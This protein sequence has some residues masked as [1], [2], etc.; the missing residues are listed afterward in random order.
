MKL[1]KNIVHGGFMIRNVETYALVERK[2]VTAGK[3]TGNTAQKPAKI[4]V[5]VVT[6]TWTVLNHKTNVSRASLD[7]QL[8]RTD[9]ISV[10]GQN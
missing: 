2:N 1:M 4:K 6:R 3:I 9:K 10:T 5:C 7:T 8:L